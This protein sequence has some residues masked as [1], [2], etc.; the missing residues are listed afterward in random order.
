MPRKTTPGVRAAA[1]AA[2]ALALLLIVA[3]AIPSAGPSTASAQ[4]GSSLF[5][6]KIA[7]NSND[8]VYSPTTKRLYASVPSSAGAGGNTI[9]PI[10]PATGALGTPV[11]IGSEPNKLAISDDGITLYASLD[12]AFAVRRMNVQTQTPGSQFALGG[13]DSLGLFTVNDIG[14]APGARDTVAGARYYR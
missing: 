11:F 4:G 13:D 1:A 6:R 12:G 3:W 8:L 7:L 2:T 5:V 9:T 14:V 10:D